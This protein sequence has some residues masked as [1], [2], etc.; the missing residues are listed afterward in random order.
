MSH[1]EGLAA[2]SAA[3]RSPYLWSLVPEG[4]AQMQRYVETALTWRDAGTAVPFAIVRTA[5]NAIVGS[6]R[7][8]DLARWAWP[9]GHPRAGL[10]K[11]DTGEIGYTWLR[12][13]A[14]GT[15]TNVQAKMLLLTQAFE[16]WGMQ[17]VSFCTDERNERSAR[18][19]ERLG[20]TFEGTLHSH[21]LAADGRPRNSRCYAIVAADWPRI[22]EHLEER[23]TRSGIAAPQGAPSAL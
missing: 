5:D 18:A 13:D 8:F 1:I 11:P 21:R 7:F 4:L 9:P 16:V 17:R 2:A 19:I 15:D 6:T 12:A 20:A 14:I 23:L 22:R 3:D 10:L